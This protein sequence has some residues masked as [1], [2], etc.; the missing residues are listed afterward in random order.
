MRSWQ[1]A[2]T[3]SSKLREVINNAR[4][5]LP[6]IQAHADALRRRSEELKNCDANDCDDAN[7]GK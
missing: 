6:K 4:G 2:Q 7:K 1:Q 5:V 3:K